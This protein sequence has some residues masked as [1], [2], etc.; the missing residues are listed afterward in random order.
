M[1]YALVFAATAAASYDG[2]GAHY[3]ESSSAAMKP[4]TSPKPVGYTTIYPGYGKEP[5]TVTSQYQPYPTCVSAGYGGKDCGKWEDDKYVSTTIKDYDQKVV[6]I[7][8]VAQ[9]V[10][11]YHTKST[12]THSAGGKGYPTSSAGYAQP[13]GS[14]YKNGTDGCWYELYEKIEE[15][16]YNQLGPHAMPGYPGSGMYADGDKKQPVHVKEYKGG[17]WSE[18]EHV[19]YHGTPKEEVTTYGK[20]GVYTVPAK[21]VTFDYPVAHPAEAT[22]TAKAGETCT[23]GGQ[24]INADKTGYVTGAY[25]A[26]ETKVVG[27]KTVTETVVKYTTVYAS[28]TGKVMVAEPTTTVYAHDTVVAYP[29]AETYAP[30]VYKYEAQTVTVTKGGE[31]YTCSYEKPTATHHNDNYPA[32]PTG[33]PAKGDDGYKASA[34]PNKPTVDT[35][36]PAYPANSTESYKHDYPASSTAVVYSQ[37]YDNGH[38]YEAKST[39][40]YNDKDYPHPAPTPI[41]DDKY[42][43]VEA[44]S[45]STPCASSTAVKPSV[46]TPVYGHPE[47]SVHAPA[48]GNPEPSAYAPVYGHPEPSPSAPAPAKSSAAY[49]V[50][51]AEPY[52]AQPTPD[53]YPA[54]P[55]HA[56][57]TPDAYPAEPTH[58]GST[59]DAYPA[60]PYQGP[61]YA[62]REKMMERRA[63]AL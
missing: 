11:V 18:Y 43:H 41:F 36:Y 58:T 13:T 30:G 51:P 26:W 24:Y 5:V 42:P 12:I 21:T 35:K 62:K 46:Y 16:P 31:A 28:S 27:D 34:T 3:A 55:T 8:K 29:I 23:Y 44:K 19:Y 20:P 57:P 54:E 61:S 38:P 45:S 50:Y 40:V 47:P 32:Y 2:Y 63:R 22:K 37:G 9:P 7:T 49:P 14:A 4:S 39:P 6:T 53:A 25:G 52:H 1:K 15:V 17:K 10:M 56:Q 48:Y 59:P 60:E 33:T